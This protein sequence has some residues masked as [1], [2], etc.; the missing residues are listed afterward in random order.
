MG[1]DNF[2]H[3]SNHY[4]RIRSAKCCSRRNTIR[5]QCIS[6]DE[7]AELKL[8][9]TYLLLLN[10]IWQHW[11]CSSISSLNEHLGPRTASSI[12]GNRSSVEFNFQVIEVTLTKR[13]NGTD[14]HATRLSFERIKILP[15]LLSYSVSLSLEHKRF[16]TFFS[17]DSPLSS[18]KGCMRVALY[19]QTQVI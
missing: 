18:S 1:C 5:V 3:T 10:W 4:L 7:R 6:L 17:M 8:L 15:S 13:T 19:R 16:Y 9:S 11:G 14:F 2:A 12:H